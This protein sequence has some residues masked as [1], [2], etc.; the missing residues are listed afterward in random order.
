MINTEKNESEKVVI[1]Q[2]LR[3]QPS[4]FL[5]WLILAKIKLYVGPSEICKIVMLVGS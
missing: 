3:E 4:Q 5:F 1:K 2:G